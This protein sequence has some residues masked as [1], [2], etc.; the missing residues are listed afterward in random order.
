MRQQTI[1]FVGGGNMA[2]AL[3][4]GLIDDGY[5]PQNIWVSDLDKQKL[6]VL[7][8][9]FG[10]NI[11]SDNQHVVEHAQV[12]VL[13]VKPQTMRQVAEEISQPVLRL[14]PVIVSIA[15]GIRVVDLAKWLGGGVAIV[16]C[17]PNTPALVRTA[18]T[19]LYANDQ[20]SAEQR[21]VAESV[22]RAVGLVAWVD[23]ESALDIVTALSGS[24][25][26]YFFLLMES[27]ERAALE[28][29]LDTETA[30]LLIEQT[31][32]GATK[33]ALEVEGA[34]A[35]LRKRVTS[36]GGTTQYA[37]D[38][39]EKGDFSDLVGS[40]LCAAYERSIELSNELGGD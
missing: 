23:K 17:M 40:A 6:N 18:A 21:D 32:F 2:T 35:E 1:G 31:A 27:M 9:Q 16:R 20:V 37:I 14:K 12:L 33:L 30:R 13:S 28:L 15:A 3:I 26:A 22:M 38:V 25:P 4:S 19:A 10:L 39:F 29:G 8:K 5:A 11:T 34:P 36:P 24:G 7:A